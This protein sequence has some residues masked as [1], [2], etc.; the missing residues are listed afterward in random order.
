MPASTQER[1]SDSAASAGRLCVSG[2]TAYPR[3]AAGSRVRVASFV[4][5]L[6]EHSVDLE[7]RPTLSEPDY[8]VIRSSAPAARKAAVLARST[9]RLAGRGG[10]VVRLVHRFRSLL[11]APGLDPPRRV[12]VYDFDDAIFLGSMHALQASR[13][14]AR[15]GWAKRERQRSLAYLRRAAVVVAGNAFLADHARSYARRVEVIPSC[16]DPESQPLQDHGEREV[17]TVGWL[18]SPSTSAY[19]RSALPAFERVNGDRLR[20]RLVLVGADRSID[21]PFVEHRP[22][23]LERERSDLASFDIGIMPVVDDDWGRGK[24]GYK[25]LQY[26]SA[27]VPAIASPVGVNPSLV[28][29]E[30]GLLAVSVDDWERALEELVGDAAARRD[31]GRAARELAQREYSYRRWA[32]PLAELLIS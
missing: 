8:E 20:A 11:P 32:G 26:F 9:A 12:D 17:V 24:C 22:W 28:G 2:E 19:L 25:I 14:N 1:T 5:F 13:V 29:N 10:G 7:Y 27:G 30:R 4:P 23:S 16:V 31:A 21:A 6:R 3:T 18:G 15:F